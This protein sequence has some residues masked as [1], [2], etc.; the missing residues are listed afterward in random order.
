[1]TGETAGKAI[2]IGSGIAGLLAARVLS[3]RFAEVHVLEKD[4]EPVAPT[5][6]KGVPQGHHVHVLLNRGETI[7][8][9]LFP[10]FR[11]AL[12]DGGSVPATLGRDV[13]W[14]VAGRWMPKFDKGMETFFQ[15]RPFLEQVIRTFVS[16][17]PTIHF[18]YKTA[19]TGFDYAETGSVRS[20]R[21][22]T[23]DE[24]QEVALEADLFVE[25]AGRGTRLDQELQAAGFTPVPATRVEVDF[26]YASGLFRLPPSENRDW[27][28][29]LI[30]PKAPEETRAAA[31]VPVEGDQWLV[32]AAGYNGDHPP[33][34]A[35]GF[36]AFIGTLSQPHIHTVLQDA[37]LLGP[38]RPF[39]F[40]AGVRRHFGGS[41]R[42]PGNL[43]VLGDAICSA[44]P[45]FGQG[46]AVAAQ[47]AMVLRD[48]VKT[49]GHSPAAWPDRAQKS[50]YR[51]ID[52][53]LDISWGL[54]IGEDLKYPS[55]SG[56]KPFGFAISR[57]FKDRVM[58][59]N[60]PD[61]ARQFYRVMHF[62]ESPLTLLRPRILKA[63]FRGA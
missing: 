21:A 49:H 47:E 4:A 52:R 12:L 62:A 25:A 45:F 59:S 28:A 27:R 1:M 57:F 30:Y 44:N 51:D 38:I 24:E 15:T 33:L 23:Q 2:V 26:A 13:N 53:I 55:T 50:F 5:P 8:E 18:H 32:T 54:A 61:V 58:S 41:N 43:L 42:T 3:E 11:K 29:M 20:V 6:R 31:I 17:I 10:G 14:H 22:R 48:L 19:V 37:E 9:D 36:M 46:I 63:L 35:A 56:K 34:D 16:A 39:K 40:K 7:L 60:D